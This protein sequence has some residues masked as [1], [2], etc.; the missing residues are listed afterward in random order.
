MLS[1]QDEQLM[2]IARAILSRPDFILLGH[3]SSSLNQSIERKILK[4]LDQRGITCISFCDQ[5]PNREFHDL[6]VEFGEGG[7][8]QVIDVKAGKSM[9]G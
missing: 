1:L 4:L 7:T 8:W 3:L 5:L 2:A 6:C 9:A